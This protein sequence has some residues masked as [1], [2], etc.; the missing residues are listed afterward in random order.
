M[1][2]S[3]LRDGQCSVSLA[4]LCV[5]SYVCMRTTVKHHTAVTE[6]HSS[7]QRFL[8]LFHKLGHSA[9]TSAAPGI[10]NTVTYYNQN[11]FIA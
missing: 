8:Y 4:A 10:D 7:I 3:A 1:P 6:A 2:G 5:A 11:L 9:Y